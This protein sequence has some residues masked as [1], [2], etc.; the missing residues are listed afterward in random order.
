MR[1]RWGVSKQTGYRPKRA[2]WCHNPGCTFKNLTPNHAPLSTTAS[3]LQSQTT[4]TP[5]R[6]KVPLLCIVSVCV[7]VCMWVCVCVWYCV[8]MCVCVVCMYVCVHV[9]GVCVC[10]WWWCVYVCMWVCIHVVVVVVC[11]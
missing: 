4:Q 5:S 9:Y 10:V 2:K 8:C 3:C 7:Y 11:V 6:L 1:V